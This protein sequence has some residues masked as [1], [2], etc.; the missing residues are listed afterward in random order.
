M[1]GKCK[2]LQQKQIDFVLT[3][4]QNINNIIRCDMSNNKNK[5]ST[6][7]VTVT[8][9][10]SAI[11]YVLYLIPHFL[12]IFKLPFFPPWLDLQI[13]DLPALLA[14]FAIGPWASIAVIVV[15]CVLKMPFT[16]TACVGELADILVGI[17]FVIV[18]SILYHRNKRRKVA[19][20]G[21]VLGTVVA[22]A[23]SV[24][25]NRFVLVPFYS[26]LWG[27]DNVL[28]A[29]AKLYD[30]DNL[31]E[32]YNMYLWLAVLPFNLLRCLICSVVTYFVYKPL[33]KLLHW[34]SVKQLATKPELLYN[35]NMDKF[36]T[37]SA[38][39]TQ[40]LA[41]NFAKTL[42]GGEVILLQG[43]LGAG[44]THFVKG[45]AEG[46]GIDEV[47]TSP[48]F[49]LHNQYF[50]RLILNHFD[51]YRIENSEEVEMLGLNEFFG[52]SDGVCAIEWSVNVAD[53]LPN[54]VITIT[55]DKVDDNSRQITI[56][57]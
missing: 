57:R 29:V 51:F 46:L 22:L 2:L 36:F 27:L 49:A 24:V 7:H 33:S 55:I 20:I 14:G 35:T 43:D 53:L 16:T 19:V 1:H 56:K 52:Q 5:I 45:L 38:L 44:K 30:V 41:C 8:A 9:V 28:G 40:S 12:P 13:S 48:T 25:A 18:P 37:T 3:L 32:F 23:V 50:G 10:L 4:S 26:D 31:Q 21:M 34:E 6:Q 39:Q 15:K 54:K 17:S 47:I 11:A 42:V